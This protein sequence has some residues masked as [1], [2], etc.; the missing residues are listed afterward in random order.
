MI[1]DKDIWN[2]PLGAF[3]RKTAK[4]GQTEPQG[5]AAAPGSGPEGETCRTCKHLYRKSMAKTYL[6]CELMKHRWTGGGK[7]DV[8][9]KD[10]ACA[11]WEA[12]P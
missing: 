12:K 7:T 9:A 11:R 5:H 8:R 4:R 6:K 1:F 2:L 3:K 10:P